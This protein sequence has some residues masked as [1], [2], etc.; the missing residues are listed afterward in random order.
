MERWILIF[1]NHYKK[2]ITTIKTTMKISGFCFVIFKVIKNKG[3][4]L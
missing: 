1:Y 3:E 2:P 4:L